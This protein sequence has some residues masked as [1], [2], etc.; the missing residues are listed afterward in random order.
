MKLFNL[1]LS[2][3]DP[4]N[5]GD[6]LKDKLEDGIE[7]RDYILVGDESPLKQFEFV[8]EIADSFEYVKRWKAEG[9]RKN[10][11]MYAIVITTNDYKVKGIIKF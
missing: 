9:A 6:N 1:V 11:R 3:Y 5:I 7:Q 8:E 2:K 10:Y 4:I